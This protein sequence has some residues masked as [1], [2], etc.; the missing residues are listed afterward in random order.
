[1]I[2]KKQDGFVP[3]NAFDFYKTQNTKKNIF[4]TSEKCSSPKQDDTVDAT[5]NF[6]STDN[7]LPLSDTLYLAKGT[8]KA[9]EFIPGYSGFIP[10]NDIKYNK[11]TLNNPYTNINKVNHMIN[12]RIRIPG[13]GGYLSGNPV[14]IKGNPRPLCLST[15]GEKFN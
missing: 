5:N 10:N 1:M 2:N 7:K 11:T 13:Y 14:N 15:R 8:T 6:K 12:Y 9:S 3:S 4:N